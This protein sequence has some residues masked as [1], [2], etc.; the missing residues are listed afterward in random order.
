MLRKIE[1]VAIVKNFSK[2][3]I[4]YISDHKGGKQ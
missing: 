2:S 4:A 1:S 3:S